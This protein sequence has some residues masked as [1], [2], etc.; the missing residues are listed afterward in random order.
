MAQPLSPSYD[1]VPYEGGI[2]TGTHPEHLAA[3]AR[4][5]GIPAAPA[6]SC[7]LLEIGCASAA[8]LLPMAYGLP[9]STFVGIDPSHR[10]VE[11]GRAALAE[12]GLTNVELHT[13][14]A[15]D[16]LAWDRKFDYIVCHGVFSWVAPDVREEILE[17]CRKLLAPAGIAYVSYNTLPGFH[18]R[19]AIMEMMR[20]HGLSFPDPKERAE[21]SRALLQFLVEATGKFD[22]GQRL[23][24]AYHGTLQE[25]LEFLGP[26]RD[27]YLLHEHFSE[28]ND[29]FYLHE[30]VDM[31]SEH[32][33][34]YLGDAAFHT[35]LV[36]DLPQDTAER[37]NT[38]ASSQVA[39]EQY[40]DFV[41]NR[42]FRKSLLTQAELQV[43]R[44]ISVDA[45]ASLTF[46]QR[47][48]KPKPGE[49]WRIVKTGNLAVNVN[50]SVVEQ[51]LTITAEA[52]PLALSFEELRARAKRELSVEVDREKLAAVLLSLYALDAIDFRTWTPHMVGHVTERP[53]AF[54]PARRAATRRLHDVPL[55]LHGTI[56]LDPFVREVLPFVDG[57]RTVAQL[58]TGVADGIEAG[59]FTLPDLTPEDLPERDEVERL[60]NESLEE[61]R[62]NG[63]LQG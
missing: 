42:M 36:N 60:V 7:R 51:V 2:V 49:Q 62:V 1:D 40:R 41:V 63:L 28:Y 22:L 13:A 25:E 38:I 45:I 21:Q 37:L 55:P 12:Y 10:Q 5:F 26:A 30:F 54:E 8:N 31:A 32:G 6:D 56:V 29:A 17:A 34:A 11:M 46:R 27:A 59:T 57:T 43:E 16:I 4:L 33:L 50:D 35:M 52:S 20:F 3:I 47:T 18:G 48:A 14:G 9:N 15:G 19:A 58:V 24:S 39:L 53:L 61:M 23:A 44:H